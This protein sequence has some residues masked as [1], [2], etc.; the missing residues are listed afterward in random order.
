MQVAGVHRPAWAEISASAIAHNVRAIKAVVGDSLFCA[1]VKA[2]AYGHGAELAAKAALVGG[3]DLLA[4]AI[5]DEGI[6]LRAMGVT[7]PILLLAEAPSDALSDALANDLT[8]TIGSLEGAHAAAASAAQSGGVHKVHLKVD[9]GMRRMGV[10]P[11]DV[12]DVIDV[13]LASSSLEVEGVYTHFSVADGSSADARAFTRSQIES[14]GEVVVALALR[15]V[16][17]KLLHAANSAGA[18]GYPEARLSMVRI[19]LSLYGYLPEPWLALALEEQGQHLEPA[20]TLRANVSAV[21]RAEAGER[22]SYGRL[23][24]LDA[25]ATIATVPFGYAD[26]YP[27]R[28]FASGA[29]VLINSKRYPLAGMVTMDQLLVDCGDDPVEVGDDVVLLG[30][31]GDE[32]I[33]ADEWAAHAGTISWEILCGIGARVP[34]TLV[35]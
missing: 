20:L 32:V 29:Q 19:G 12:I 21:R 8:L 18:L 22:P 3:A 34:R 15:G 16:T 23:R 5:V 17:P 26:G 25:P 9:T 10:V 7:A 24:A 4:V 6:E 30:R 35:N 31:Q 11:G 28:L 1:V 14:F 27:R 33:T 13:L 2:N